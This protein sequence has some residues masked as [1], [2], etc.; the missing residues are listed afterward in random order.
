[1]QLTVK[2]VC[3][4]I[5][6]LVQEFCNST[7]ARQTQGV[8]SL[9]YIVYGCGHMILLVDTSAWRGGREEG[10]CTIVAMTSKRMLVSRRVHNHKFGSFAQLTQ[11]W[12]G[13]TLLL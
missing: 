4:V 8:Q 3:F 2:H 5:F 10:G 13:M 11:P 7:H 6:V 9:C 12:M 1:M